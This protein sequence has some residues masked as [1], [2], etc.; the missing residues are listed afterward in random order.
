MF[1]QWT[2]P[3]SHVERTPKRNG[4]EMKKLALAI[5]ILP[6]WANAQAQGSLTYAYDFG[7]KET[8]AVATTPVG[9][10]GN[11]LGK[12]IS[13][14]VDMFGGVT[15]KS[16]TPIAGFML[17]KRFPLA[18]QAGGYI[19]AGLSLSAGKNPSPVIGAGVSWWF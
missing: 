15:F 3:P 6:S 18:D 5:T 13:L 16:K 11:V 4:D 12:G 7:L 1:T 19:G 8:A 14:D 2:R 10:L 17:G 9:T